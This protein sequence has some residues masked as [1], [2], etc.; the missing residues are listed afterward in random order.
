MK[1]IVFLVLALYFWVS[2]HLISLINNF[3]GAVAIIGDA[4]ILRR[5]CIALELRAVSRTSTMQ[6]YDREI[7]DP[8]TRDR[9]VTDLTA[10]LGCFAYDVNLAKFFDRNTAVVI[11]MFDGYWRY[12][13]INYDIHRGFYATAE[14]SWHITDLLRYK[15]RSADSWD[16]HYYF[17]Y[18]L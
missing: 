18:F 3:S 7:T 6:V 9:Y 4:V 17:A 16:N 15:E 12:Y 8:T 2:Y 14:E 5:G 10:T 13:M 1:K 11:K